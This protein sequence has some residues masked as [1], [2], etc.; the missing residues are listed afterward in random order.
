[1]EHGRTRI[2]PILISLAF[3]AG[4]FYAGF[5]FGALRASVPPV[6][7]NVIH[8]ADGKPA[9]VDFALFW[10]VWSTLNEKY[11]AATSTSDQEKVWGA[12]EGLA[13]SFK[14][15]YTTFFPPKEAAVFNQTITGNF[16]GVGMEIG[17][18]NELLT[19]IAPLPDTPASRAGVHSGDVI[20]QIDDTPTGNLSIERA[21]SLIR[22]E[23]GTNV[24]IVFVREGKK[25]PLTITLTR[26]VIVVPTTEIEQ[27]PD[28]IFVLRLFNFSANAPDAFRA[29]LRTFASSG[30]TKLLIDLRGNPGGYLEAAIDIA[31]WFLPAGK[32][33]VREDVGQG[34]PERVHRSR[35]YD[36]FNDSLQLAILVDG[37]SASASEILAG[38]LQDYHKGTLIGSKTFGKGSV[39]ELINLDGGSYLKVTVARWLT[40]NGHSISKE[41][42]TPDIEVTVKPEDIAKGK[43]PQRDAAV[44]FLLKK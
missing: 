3:L 43:D 6:A 16:G 19:V 21:V 32:V 36:I 17:L 41:G 25:E 10:K 31:S 22:G 29:A 42:L 8:Q 28:G 38:A 27:R 44:R 4:V 12:I 26:Q 37:G 23:V 9:A 18:K 13:A 14:D 39:Q 35:G 2:F 1:M 40:P 11:V 33:V 15:P 24:K 30:S 34:T 5:V 7:P 20:V